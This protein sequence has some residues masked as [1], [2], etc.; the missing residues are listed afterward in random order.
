MNGLWAPR[1]MRWV[2]LN[3]ADA[4]TLPPP[5][6]DVLAVDN[7]GH[8]RV[9]HMDGA[10]GDLVQSLS[11]DTLADLGLDDESNPAVFGYAVAWMAL[12]SPPVSIIDGDAQYESTALA[13]DILSDIEPALRQAIA[14]HLSDGSS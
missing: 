10:S 14:R 9:V 2:R 6:V 1:V 3:Y 11:A 8:M 12:P 5:G 13:S 4:A 7:I